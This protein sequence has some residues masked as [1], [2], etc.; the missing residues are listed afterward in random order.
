[1]TL[2]NFIIA[3]APKCGTTALWEY[4]ESHPEVALCTAKEPRFFSRLVGDLER[5]VVSDGHKWS[6]NF[7]RGFD[8]YASLFPEQTSAKAVGEATTYYFSSSDSPALIREHLPGVRLIFMLRDPAARAYSNYWQEKKLGWDLPS[9]D[10]MAR[11]DHPR[12]RYYRRVSSYGENLQRWLDVFPAEQVL[13]LLQEDLKRAPLD[14]FRRVCAFLGIAQQHEPAKLGA[15]INEQTAPRFRRI[16]WLL[17]SASAGRLVQRLPDPVRRSLGAV[18]RTISS[19]NGRHISYPPM[20]ADTRALMVSQ[21]ADEIGCVETLL[22]RSLP[23]W[24]AVDARS[25]AV[26]AS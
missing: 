18:R 25:G 1:M 26:R 13:V 7:D 2:P 11:D 10:D 24:R 14:E 19:L 23:A 12:Y 8:W 5:G 22:G 20:S 9:F 21:L 15:N 16:E 4:L 3:G 17:R 6:G